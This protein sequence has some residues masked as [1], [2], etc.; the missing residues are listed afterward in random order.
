[1]NIKTTA[2]VALL[3]LVCPGLLDAQKKKQQKKKTY[4]N[5]YTAAK[6]DPDFLLQGEYAKPGTG[7]QLVAFGA[8]RFRVVTYAGGLPGLGWDGKTRGHRDVDTAEASKAVAEGFQKIQ[9]RST[10][11]G[12]KAPQGATVLFDGTKASLKNWKKGARI[13]KGGLLMAG[14]TSLMTYSNAI[15]HVEFL[16]PYKPHARGQGRGNSGLYIQ[17]RYET[18]MLDSFGLA[19]KHNECGGIY[20]VK[21]PDL[22]MCLPPLTWQTYDVEIKSAEF[23]AAGK[24]TKNARMTVRLNGVVVQDNVEV[25]KRTTASPLKEGPTPGPVY[26]QGHG[27]PV[28]YRNVWVLPR[29]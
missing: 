15:V 11:L 22:N 24:K 8:G 3:C 2:L 4:T 7:V 28:S 21:D 27:N 5:A 12:A 6:E 9:R 26:L 13:S 25:P 1:M 19:G 20:S 18:Q 14:V 23:D 16:L 29:D 17:G 10:T